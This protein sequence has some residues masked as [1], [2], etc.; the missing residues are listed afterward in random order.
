MHKMMKRQLRRCTHK[1]GQVDIDKLVDMINQTYEEADDTRRLIEGTSRTLEE[2]VM[3]LND[4]IKVE[5]SKVKRDPSV[6]SK[7]FLM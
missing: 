3:Q 4:A 6:S 5:M 1:N 7:R 2:E